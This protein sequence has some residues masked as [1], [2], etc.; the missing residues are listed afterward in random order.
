MLSYIRSVFSIYFLLSLL[1]L[2]VLFQLIIHSFH[3]S[4]GSVEVLDFLVHALLLLVTLLLFVLVGKERR[5]QETEAESE[6]MDE[7]L[8]KALKALSDIKFALDESSMLVLYSPEGIILDVNEK[9]CKLT[10]YSRE[11]LV[12]KHFMDLQSG[13]QT[14]EFFDR[15]THTVLNGE[16]W[17]GELKNKTKDGSDYW[18]DATF[19]PI[20]DDEGKTCQIVSIRTD[21]T[22]R[23]KAEETAEHLAYHDALTGLPNRKLFLDRLQQVLFRAKRKKRKFAIL[24]LDL[25]RFRWINDSYG[26]EKGDLLLKRIAEILNRCLGEE[27][28]ISR[29]GGDEFIILLPEVTHEDGVTHAINR[30]LS[31]L[32]KPIEWEGTELYVTVSIGAVVYPTDGEDAESLMKNVD[33]ALFT[34]KQTRNTYHFFSQSQ[35]SKSLDLLQ[36]ESDLHKAIKRNELMVYYQ[37]QVHLMTG[38]ILGLEAL[39][40]WK[41][42]KKGYISPARFIPLAEQTGLIEEIGKWVMKSA[43]EQLK[44][45]LDNGFPPMKVS[46]NLS[47]RQFQ[48]PDLVDMVAGILHETG[49]DPAHLQLEIT[50]SMTADV[51]YASQLL[52]QLKELGVRISMDDF[53]TG[54]S[55]L[56]YLRS[57]PLDQLKIDHSFVRAITSDPKDAAIV[58]TII[59]MAHNLGLSVIAEG[60]ETEEQLHFLKEKGS[61]GIQGYLFSPPLAPEVFEMTF[62]SLQEAAATVMKGLEFTP[63]AKGRG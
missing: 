11:E 18:V 51:E 6:R 46:V 17:R 5:L 54:F 58:K 42:P 57:F 35:Q 33:Q 32:K 14:Q 2:S 39:L 12:G 1:F 15:I 52:K 20:L 56:H 36:M 50:E 34:A 43:C 59:E 60:V 19:V 25:D 26:H 24:Y 13:Y 4:K 45:W 29:P 9:V 21:I 3:L 10:G 47:L 62:H 41:H 37:P 48:Q 44:M 7:Q 40:R 38:E 49:V 27:V 53:G 28:T 30:L 63:I 8:R 22:D 61:D 31:E 16:T 55:S 23:K